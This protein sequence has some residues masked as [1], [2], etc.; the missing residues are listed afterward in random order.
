[1]ENNLPLGYWLKK[2]DEKYYNI[3]FQYGGHMGGECEILLP[4]KKLEKFC[5]NEDWERK[6]INR[7]YKI[8]YLA[9]PELNVPIP[10]SE[11]DKDG[12]VPDDWA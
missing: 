12:I 4:K 9:T 7:F 8:V 5:S 3:G 6:T 2:E 11:K 1:M 10:E